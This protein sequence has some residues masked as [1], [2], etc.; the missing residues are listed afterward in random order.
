M[1]IFMSRADIQYT[2]EYISPIFFN[3]GEGWLLLASLI[4]NPKTQV[5]VYFPLYL[6]PPL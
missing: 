2:S 3:P 1:F 5:Q 4:V 6:S